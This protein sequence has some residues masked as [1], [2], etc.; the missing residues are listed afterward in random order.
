MSSFL[1]NQTFSSQVVQSH[2]DAKQGYPI[3]IGQGLKKQLALFI[4]DLQPEP[5]SLIIIHDQALSE[6][7]HKTVRGLIEK[8]SLFLALEAG[9]R[10]KELHTFERL[11]SEVLSDRENTPD[12]QSLVLAFGG[13][14]VGDIAGFFA[15]VYLR[16]V[17]LIHLP[18]S[19][20]A[21]IDSSIGGKNALNFQTFKNII[22]S[23]YAPKGVF[24]DLDALASLPDRVYRSAFAEAIKLGV[25]LDKDFFE[26]LEKHAATL[27][28]RDV[29]SLI[30]LIKMAVELK[31]SVVCQDER[32]YGK[33]KVLN[34]GHSFGHAF[35][36]LAS[37]NLLHGEAVGIGMVH[38]AQ[39]ALGLEFLE[40]RAYERIVS[41]LEAFGLPTTLEHALGAQISPQTF[42]HSALKQALSLDKKRSSGKVTFVLPT[43]IG[44]YQLWETSEIKDVLKLLE[45]DGK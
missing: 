35:E 26:W 19:L 21:M 44:D 42:N 9:E 11:M 24:S 12:R 8:P 10:N 18:T 37:P 4:R 6:Y 14:G 15:A 32:D 33:R 27:L 40:K 22:G 23:F 1:D 17:R 13:G 43:G 20:L 16:G 30:M 29:S 2:Q 28:E 45:R 25:T 39:L 7:V 41:L 34:F 36:S 31:C 3:V 38:A 5:S